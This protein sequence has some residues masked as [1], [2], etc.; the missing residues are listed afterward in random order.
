VKPIRFSIVTC[1][2]NSVATLR[3]TVDSVNQQTYREFEHIFVDGGSTDGTLELI[4]ET[5]PA[6]RIL[7]GIGGGISAAM[8]AG[9]EVATG[10]VVAHLHS[11]DFYAGP[12]VLEWVAA[13]FKEA[14]AGWVIGDFDYLT[15][16]G[17]IPGSQVAPLSMKKLGYGNYVPHFSTFV[18]RA[19]FL[20][21]GGFDESLKYCMD[22]D[23]W[24]RLFERGDPAHV[25]HVLA[26]FRA[27]DGSVSTANRRKVLEEELRVR[28]RYWSCCPTSLPRYFIRFAKRWHRNRVI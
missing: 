13:T 9:L 21:V 23:L 19:W 17:R 2:F 16:E 14:N 4:R 5:A 20:D 22:Y 26:V 11:D 8:N 18:E 3:E 10:D 15:T 6:A 12:R 7:Y 27:H 28:I 25:P 1:T 24:F